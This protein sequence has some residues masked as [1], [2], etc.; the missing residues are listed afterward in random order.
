MIIKK[1]EEA[2]F[3]RKTELTTDTPLQLL[4]MDLFRLVNIM[5]FA[6]NKYAPVIV[7]DFSRFI[8]NYFLESEDEASEFIINHIKR[9]N[10]GTKWSVKFIKSDNGIEFKNSTIKEFC[11]DKGITQTF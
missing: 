7:D 8:C 4:Y 2:S 9:V 11:D 6:K 3:K 10:I 5:S 1:K